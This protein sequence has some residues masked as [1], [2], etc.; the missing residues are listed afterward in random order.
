MCKL[1]WSAPRPPPPAAEKRRTQ[2]TLHGVTLS[3]DYGWLKAANWREVLRDPAAL[4]GDIL[5]LIEAENGYA[6]AMLAPQAELRAA[7]VKEMR[8]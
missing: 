1:K 3:D 6:R 4:P 7:L 5:A 8:G 2:T